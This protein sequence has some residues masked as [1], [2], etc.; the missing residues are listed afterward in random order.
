MKESAMISENRVGRFSI[1]RWLIDHRADELTVI[2]GRVVIVRAEMMFDRD[3]VEYTAYSSDFEPM[4]KG[5]ITPEYNVWVEVGEEDE[6]GVCPLDVKFR[7][8]LGDLGPAT[9]I[10]SKDSEHERSQS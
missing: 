2:F 5:H 3:S 9:K 10:I 7:L 4:K 8:A 1:Q 6:N